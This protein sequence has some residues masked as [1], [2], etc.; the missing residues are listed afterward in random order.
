MFNLPVTREELPEPGL[1]GPPSEAIVGGGGGGFAERGPGPLGFRSR[2][3]GKR[4]KQKQL[5]GA[6]EPSPTNTI[7]SRHGD[8]VRPAFATVRT[9]RALPTVGRANVLESQQRRTLLHQRR[10]LF[11][12]Q[13]AKPWTFWAVSGEPGKAISAAR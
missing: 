5:S 9:M 3:L 11:S 10:A 1:S 2:P 7:A 13:S 12:E 4:R 8:S 6:P